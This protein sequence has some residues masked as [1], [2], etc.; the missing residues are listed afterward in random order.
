MPET[1]NSRSSCHPA[2]LL[3]SQMGQWVG[4]YVYLGL[5]GTAT[6]QLCGFK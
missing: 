2:L 4:S 5:P 6:S 1:G 3:S